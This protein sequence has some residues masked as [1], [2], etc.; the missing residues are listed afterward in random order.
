MKKYR[1]IFARI[2]IFFGL[3]GIFVVVGRAQPG[4]QA[5]AFTHAHTLAVDSKGDVYVAETDWGR[6]VQRF[7]PVN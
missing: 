4:H 2:G 5:G 1:G 3:V 7:R 6:R